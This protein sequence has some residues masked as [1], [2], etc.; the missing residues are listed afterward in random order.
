MILW[1]GVSREGDE[2]AKKSISGMDEVALTLGEG[3]K[4]LIRENTV[5]ELVEALLCEY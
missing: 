4:K 3:D 5:E 2:G 1:G